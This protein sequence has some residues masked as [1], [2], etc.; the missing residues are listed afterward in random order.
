MESGVSLQWSELMSRNYVDLCF[1]D[2]K[3]H[4]FGGD[5]RNNNNKIHVIET[6]VYYNGH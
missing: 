2:K 3:N 1:L 5:V 4:V 6:F